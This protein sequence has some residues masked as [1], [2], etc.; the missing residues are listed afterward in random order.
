MFEKP[1]LQPERRGEKSVQELLH[2]LQER[3]PESMERLRRFN[4]DIEEHIKNDADTSPELRAM[5]EEMLQHLADID[6][7]TRQLDAAGY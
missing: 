1:A 3:A 7:Q 6:E 5:L 4:L 2:Q